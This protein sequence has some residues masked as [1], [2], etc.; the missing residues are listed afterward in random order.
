MCD[1][2]VY[3]NKEVNTMSCGTKKNCAPKKTSAP[4]NTKGTKKG[5]C[6]K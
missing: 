1:N 3:I 4:K 6:K 2:I 5:G